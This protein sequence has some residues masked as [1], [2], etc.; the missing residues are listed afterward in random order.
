MTCRIRVIKDHHTEWCSIGW[1]M[2]LGVGVAMD[3]TGRLRRWIM[4]GDFLGILA[5]FDSEKWD[6]TA[7]DLAMDLFPI[8]VLVWIHGTFTMIEFLL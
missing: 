2:A 7:L 3:F 8:K 4:T 5:T 6:G 1:R